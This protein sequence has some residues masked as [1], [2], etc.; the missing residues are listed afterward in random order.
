MPNYGVIINAA[1]T[2]LNQAANGTVPDVSG[3]MTDWLQPLTFKLVGK[4]IN[5][6]QVV[7]TDTPILL[8]GVIQPLDKR[9]LALKPEGERAWT[10]FE[11]VAQ[12]Q[13]KLQVDD[14]VDYLGVQTRVM[15][16][17]DDTIYGYVNYELV[18]DWTGAGPTDT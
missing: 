13:P 1:N 9:R 3:A 4:I 12:P 17:G 15:A 14:V 8:Y 2:P 6:F 18:Q 11:L 5:G 16:Q 10:W 7:E